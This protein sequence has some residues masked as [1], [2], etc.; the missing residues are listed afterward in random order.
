MRLPVLSR[1][2]ITAD[3]LTGMLRGK[4]HDVTIASVELKAIGTGQVGATYRIK[5]NFDA[6]LSF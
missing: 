6:L 4:G 2:E 5:L 3:W 1:D